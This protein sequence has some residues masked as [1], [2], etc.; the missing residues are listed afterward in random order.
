MPTLTEFQT[1]CYDL[2]CE[3]RKMQEIADMLRVHKSTVSRNLHRAIKV[4]HGP[5]PH[6]ILRPNED[7]DRLDMRRVAVL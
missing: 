3:G 7:L 2:Y 1:Q 6:E 4:V 5:K